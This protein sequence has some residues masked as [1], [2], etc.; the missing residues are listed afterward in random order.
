MLSYLDLNTPIQSPQRYHYFP[1][2][3]NI[4]FHSYHSVGPI[5]DLFI[6]RVEY[7]LYPGTKTVNAKHR[8]G[9]IVKPAL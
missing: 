5:F 6:L 7:K 4:M 1:M 3:Y 9:L 8:P 2:T